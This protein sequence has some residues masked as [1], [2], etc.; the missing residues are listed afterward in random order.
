MS[1]APACVCRLSSWMPTALFH[2]LNFSDAKSS[3]FYN[4]REHSTYSLTN[5]GRGG[6]F[7]AANFGLL[8]PV[9]STNHIFR[10]TPQRGVYVVS[11]DIS[12]KNTPM[13]YAISLALFMYVCSDSAMPLLSC[14]C[15]ITA[16][17]VCLH[18]SVPSFVQCCFFSA[19]CL[20][21]H[22]YC[23]IDRWA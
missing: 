15:T 9:F 10:D 14:T 22:M 8:E 7:L 17:G 21:N 12:L 1:D 23:S 3:S 16:N 5:F 19:S 20:T 6:L 18:L 13:S 11:D 2:L 4:T